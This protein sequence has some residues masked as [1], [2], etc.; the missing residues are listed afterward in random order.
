MLKSNK[1]FTLVELIVS[2]A[3]LSIIIV[4]FLSMFNFSFLTIVNS[5]KRTDAAFNAQT[6]IDDLYA[7]SSLD[8][9]SDVR[10]YLTSKGYNEV[11]NLVDVET[12]T[13]NAVNYNLSDTSVLSVNGAS[14]T[15]VVFFNN[16]KNNVRVSAF[17]PY[18]G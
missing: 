8:D 6:I 15:V 16:N 1:G 4:A 12:Y 10:N 13:S 11:V 14:V 7:Q 2:M 5:G 3:I 18:G 9:V 17:I